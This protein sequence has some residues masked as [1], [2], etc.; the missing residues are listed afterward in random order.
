MLLPRG[1]DQLDV[2]APLALWQGAAPWV[3]TPGYNGTPAIRFP[4][5]AGGYVDVP[6]AFAGGDLTLVAWGRL[7]AVQWAY[8]S[9]ARLLEAPGLSISRH[10]TPG[11]L[12]YSCAGRQ[13]VILAGAT[14]DW[15][16]VGICVRG[17][18]LSV[19][20]NGAVVAS[21]TLTAPPMAFSAV[22]LGAA[23]NGGSRWNGYI[24]DVGLWGGAL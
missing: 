1:L 13:G 8:A 11:A 7:D 22:R 16:S 24:S 10:T 4:G 12:Y 17:A 5:S 2:P 14:A 3:A 9:F 18:A 20:F 15:F 19:A 23:A 21:H 6:A